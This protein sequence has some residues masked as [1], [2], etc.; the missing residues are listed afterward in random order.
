MYARILLH[1]HRS[2]FQCLYLDVKFHIK[3]H[4][5]VRF[6]LYSHQSSFWILYVWT[7]NV[8]LSKH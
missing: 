8:L 4:I 7:L 2:S 5:C 6:A 3:A 1:S